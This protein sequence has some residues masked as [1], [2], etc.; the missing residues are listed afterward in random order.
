MSLYINKNLWYNV[1]VMKKIRVIS[2][3]H[4]DINKNYGFSLRDGLYEDVFTIVAGVTS[5]DPSLSVKWLKENITKGIA[6]SGNHLVYN[7]KN[8]TI[9]Q[10]RNI[11]KKGLPIDGDVTYLDAD[12]GV[13][14]KVVDG[15]LFLGSCLYTDYTLP[16]K[17]NSAGDTVLNMNAAR[18]GLNDFRW[19]GTKFEMKMVPDYASPSFPV[20]N[21]KRKVCTRFL[22][23]SDLEKSFHKTIKMFTEILDTNEKSDNPLPVIVISHHAPTPKCISDVYSHSEINASYATDLEDFI[24]NHKSIKVWCCG[25]IHER[26]IFNIDRDD[27]SHCAIVQNP[28]GYIRQWYY[29]YSNF[30]PNVFINTETWEIEVDDKLV[31]NEKINKEIALKD[32]RLKNLA[33]LW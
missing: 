29:E 28:C 10:L 9:Q 4:M 32:K 22:D 3:L 8:K 14:S 18:G 20:P 16:T 6:I 24:K 15:I 30:N 26:K 23:P 33:W 25:H 17:W 11:M 1:I 13:V 5:G 27:G 12:C 7:H 2:D 19:G 31:F 21:V